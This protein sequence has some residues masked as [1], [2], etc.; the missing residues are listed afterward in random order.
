M[1]N[2]SAELQEKIKSRPTYTILDSLNAYKKIVNNVA[3]P[4][5]FDGIA[6][7]KGLLTPVRNQGTCGSCWAFASTSTLADRYNIQ[8]KGLMYIELS[9]AKLILCDWR[10]KGLSLLI[11]PTD[12][13]L[14]ED[15]GRA[16]ISSVTSSS[17]FGNSLADSVRYL[18][19]FGSV[20]ES[21]VPYDKA[22]GNVGQ[23]QKLGTFTDPVNIPLCYT[24]T[25][26]T[27]DMCSTFTF[28][29]KTGSESGIPSRFYK[30]N[31]YYGLY[32]TGPLGNELQL[33]IEI[34]RW[35]PIMVGMDVYPDFYMFDAKNDIY[36]WDGKDQKVGGHAVE[37]VGWGVE[38]GKPYWQIENTWGTEWGMDGF[39]RMIRGKNNCN[40]ETNA[41]G[42]QPDFF[43]GSIQ[44]VDLVI[45]DP[46]SRAYNNQIRADL[47]L[48][49]HSVAGGID[50]TTGYSRRVM[51]KYPWLNL[52]RPVKLSK[53]PQWDLFIA[54]KHVK[55]MSNNNI[56]NIHK[57]NYIYI[58]VSI[59]LII[60][61]IT[62][63]ILYFISEIQN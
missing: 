9:A 26:P 12:N 44:P 34:F 25:G 7:W 53:L 46:K 30:C 62:L 31:N 40:I 36:E 42:I 43:G 2:L 10:E 50:P 21:C 19:E 32:G 37:I 24:I 58:I 59:F 1:E 35:G 3:V 60:I 39:F 28:D 8:S 49:V 18:Y 57:R 41:V 55:N 56:N 14:S 17:C 33:R 13:N 27:G 51:T 5:L 29:E 38:N 6:T 16:N 23:Y 45:T 22:L 61:I 15:L 63:I 11:D 52:N 54:G 47:T 48:S 20:L 4:D